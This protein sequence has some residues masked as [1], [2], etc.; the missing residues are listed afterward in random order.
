M[1]ALESASILFVSIKIQKEKPQTV[2][3]DHSGFSLYFQHLDLHLFALGTCIVYIRNICLSIGCQTNFGVLSSV[4]APNNSELKT[5]NSKL[6]KEDKVDISAAAVKEL[7]EKTGAGIMDCKKA[8]TESEGNVEKATEYLRQKGLTTHTKVAGREVK[9][10]IV[11]SYIHTGGRI[12]ALVE[13]NCETDFVARTE[14]FRTLAREIAMQVASMNPKT[15][16]TLDGDEGDDA[17]LS[18]EY[19]R[20]SRKTIRDLIKE[21]IAKVRENIQVSRFM[22][23]EVGASTAEADSN[24]AKDEKES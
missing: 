16:G 7:R 15:V 14:E 6:P 11:E 2:L 4:F 24:G 13:V 21:T 18:Q 9:Q 23:F 8:L 17:L 22:R 1:D 10:G 3:T 19:I 12:G 5:Q 20:D